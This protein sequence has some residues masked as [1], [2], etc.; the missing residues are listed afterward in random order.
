MQITES[1]DQILSERKLITERFYNEKLFK[2]YPEFIPYFNS[3][4][5]GV[6]P[7]M[8]MMALQGV[9]CTLSGSYP[10][11]EQYLRYLGTRHRKVG[12][13]QELCPKFC[14]MLLATV[15]EYHGK[16]WDWPASGAPPWLGPPRSCWKAI[17]RITTPADLSRKLIP[18]SLETAQLRH[19][20]GWPLEEPW[21]IS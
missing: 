16:D 13:P 21:E 18:H 9:V 11:I 3:T 5:M 20:F 4:N 1:L 19:T 17:A 8:L 14:E 2:V 6:Q 10:A 15:E 7:M 12:I